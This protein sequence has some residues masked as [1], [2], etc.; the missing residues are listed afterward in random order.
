MH[1]ARRLEGWTPDKESETGFDNVPMPKFRIPIMFWRVWW[2]SEMSYI[3][4]HEKRPKGQ[5]FT[6]IICV[7]RFN[8]GGEMVF[9]KLLKCDKG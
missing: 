3:M 4:G 2:C 6:P 5:K 9:N 1:M 8:G 7:K